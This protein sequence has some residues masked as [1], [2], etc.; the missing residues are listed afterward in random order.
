MRQQ[1]TVK[2]VFVRMR[3]HLKTS[4]AAAAQTAHERYSLL[5]ASI[6]DYR[7]PHDIQSSPLCCLVIQPYVSEK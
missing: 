6:S 1:N 3:V 4:A 5:P 7:W 2:R